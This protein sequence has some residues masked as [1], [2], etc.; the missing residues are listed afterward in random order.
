MGERVT[1]K[2]SIYAALSHTP[3]KS[4][5]LVAMVVA[6]TDAVAVVAVSVLLLGA[7]LQ[8]V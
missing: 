1:F 8:A 7:V 2:S 6:P 4:A 3:F 5:G